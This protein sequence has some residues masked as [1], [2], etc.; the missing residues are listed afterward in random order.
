MPCVRFSCGDESC[1]AHGGWLLLGCDSRNIVYDHNTYHR[2]LHIKTRLHDFRR[3]ETSPFG[4]RERRE[5][6]LHDLFQVFDQSFRDLPLSPPLRDWKGRSIA[7]GS[8][9]DFIWVSVPCPEYSRDHGPARPR[10]GRR[11]RQSCRPPDPLAE[12]QGLR[13]GEP[14]GHVPRPGI[15][16]TATKVPQGNIV[17][18]VRLPLLQA[19]GY[20]HQHQLLPSSLPHGPLQAQAATRPPPRDGPE[21]HVPEWNSRKHARAP[22]PSAEGAHPAALPLRVL[23]RPRCPR[24]LPSGRR[25]QKRIPPPRESGQGK[26]ERRA[27]APSTRRSPPLRGC[28]RRNVGYGDGRCFFP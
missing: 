17:L 10:D 14:A 8:C 18:Q 27:S 12:A 25:L 22:A 3:L 15:H 13:P 2:I 20:H 4:N 19:H 7:R 26:E 28:A 24:E 21:G 23:S 5:E 1:H 9:N 16:A 6:T 11:Y